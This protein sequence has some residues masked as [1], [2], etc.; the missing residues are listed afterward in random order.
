MN[1]QFASVISDIAG[2]TGLNILRA[3]NA[4]KRNPWVLSDMK[5]VRS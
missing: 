5:N 4:G 3:I 2:E 1:I